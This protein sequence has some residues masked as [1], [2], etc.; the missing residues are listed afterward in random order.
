MKLRFKSIP[1]LQYDDW[2]LYRR[3]GCIHDDVLSIKSC[4]ERKPLEIVEAGG[5]I[6]AAANPFCQRIEVDVFPKSE[7]FTGVVIVASR[8]R[9]VDMPGQ[10]A[11][12]LFC[13]EMDWSY[14]SPR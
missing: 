6:N 9:R 2:L 14:I 1:V 5:K 11:S 10:A 4:I 13:P 7:P 12:N 8:G 3:W